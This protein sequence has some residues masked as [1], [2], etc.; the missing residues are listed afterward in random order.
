M[1]DPDKPDVESSAQDNKK[2]S[3]WFL[4]ALLVA[5]G[6]GVLLTLAWCTGSWMDM[7]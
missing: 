4:V 2:G 7:V 5:L 3:A 6:L 1:P